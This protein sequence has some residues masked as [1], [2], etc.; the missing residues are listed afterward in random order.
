MTFFRVFGWTLLAALAII[1]IGA[2]IS[3]VHLNLAG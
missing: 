3:G 2:I 1:C